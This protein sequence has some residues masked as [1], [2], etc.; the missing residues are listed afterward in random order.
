MT[1]DALFQPT[2]FAGKPLKNRFVLAPLT[3]ARAGDSRIPNPLMA[4]YYRQ[5]AT[6]GMVITEATV[7]S[8]QGIGWVGTP[9]IYTEAMAEGWKQVTQAIH[10]EGSQAV[11]QLW[12][13]GR[14]SHSSFHNGELPV[15]ASAVKLEGDHIHTPEGNQNY[16][17]PR[18]LTVEE[19]KGV[20][21]SYRQAAVHAKAAGFDGIEVH[22]AN[23]YLINQFLDGRSNIRDDEYGGSIEN[24]FRL[25]KEVLEAIFEIW[26]ANAVGV[27]LS[28]N[29]IFNDMGFDGYRETYEYVIQQ[30]SDM[31]LGYLHVMD[32]LA[33]GFHERGAP[34]TLAEIRPMFSG[35]VIGNCGYSAEDGGERIASGDA[36]LV[37][38]GRPYITNP[39]LPERIKNDWPLAPY[40]D[41]SQWY[42]AGAEGYTDYPVYESA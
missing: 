21:A 14:A 26:P 7:V 28:P 12:H 8:T 16:E 33:F 9:G 5:R 4:E 20:V 36:D 23:G 32:G 34:F 11:V 27:R 37:A 24:R 39:D 31:K 25:L 30:L 22:A 40:D 6:A 41:M 38:Y 3:R 2:T 13:C 17:T 35:L 10:D 19:I 1:I 18:A 15:S 42:G 29:G